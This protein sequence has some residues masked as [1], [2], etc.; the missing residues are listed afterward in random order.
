MGRWLACRLGV[1]LPTLWVACADLRLED[2][3]DGTDASHM[4]R[5]VTTMMPLES[6]SDTNGIASQAL[7]GPE[8]TL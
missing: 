5:V 8:M 4:A 2:A 1:L 7:A 6:A 3:A